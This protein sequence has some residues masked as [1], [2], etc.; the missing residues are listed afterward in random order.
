RL[1]ESEPSDR[2]PPLPRHAEQPVS[3]GRA[4][5]AGPLCPLRPALQHQLARKAVRD[6]DRKDIPAGFARGRGQS[7]LTAGDGDPNPPL[8][9]VVYSY[10]SRRQGGL[11]AET[12]KPR[13]HDPGPRSAGSEFRDPVAAGKYLKQQDEGEERSAPSSQGT[14]KVAPW[15]SWSSAKGRCRED[16]A[17]EEG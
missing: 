12:T 9:V 8:P 14:R 16:G 3:G 15:W 13:D 6:D 4:A 17:A 1:G 5:R 11:D 7:G 2:A 10:I